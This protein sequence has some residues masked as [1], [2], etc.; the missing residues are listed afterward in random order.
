VEGGV[1]REGG[2]EAV[3]W[4]AAGSVGARVVWRA[5]R[6]A[7]RRGRGSGG[8]GVCWKLMGAHGESG[9]AGGAGVDGDGGSEYGAR[10]GV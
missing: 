7:V 8:D 9:E 2:A 1:G 6:R 10:R 4:I 5:V 3:Y